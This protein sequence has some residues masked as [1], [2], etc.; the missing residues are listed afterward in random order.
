MLSGV[1]YWLAIAAF[2]LHGAGMIGA[3]GYLPFDKK[4]GF[5]GASWLLGSGTAATV[6]G[7]VVWAVAGIGYVVAAYGLWR[8][9]GWWQ[10]AALVGAIAT[11]IAI[12]LWFGKVPGGV[13]AGGALAIATIVLVT[14][15]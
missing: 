11:L 13:Y 4:G 8:E 10:S 1:W 3:A 12:A 14:V 6:V 5:I 9:L 15:I 2:A 7:V